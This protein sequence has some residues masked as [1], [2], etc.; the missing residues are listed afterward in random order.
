MANQ[1]ETKSMESY[2]NQFSSRKSRR[3]L[4]DRTPSFAN[5]KAQL[6]IGRGRT[7]GRSTQRYGTPSPLRTQRE[8]SARKEEI[9]QAFEENSE[10]LQVIFKAFC[11][12]TGGSETSRVKNMSLIKLFKDAGLVK[13]GLFSYEIT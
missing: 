7:S 6:S 1:L 2:S 12:F 5:L 10:I 13:V 11:S 9:N 8:T 3:G 4:E